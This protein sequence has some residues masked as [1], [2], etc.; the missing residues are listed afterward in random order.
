MVSWRG[1]LFRRGARDETFG[2]KKAVISICGKLE[3]FG[4][5]MVPPIILILRSSLFAASR[6]MQARLGPHG[7]RRRCAAPHH[8]GQI[9]LAR[10][11]PLLA[12]RRE[13][14]AAAPDG[15]DH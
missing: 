5:G 15:A 11:L 12:R 13:Q 14:I 1:E 4:C 7:S 10:R 2:R 9:A 8:E 6:R 3:D